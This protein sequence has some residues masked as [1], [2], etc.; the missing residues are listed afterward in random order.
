MG[1]REKRAAGSGGKVRRWTKSEVFVANITSGAIDPRSD[2]FLATYE[3]RRL[4]MVVIKRDGARCACCGASP[5]SGAVINVDHIKPR[6]LFPQLAM[7]ENNLQVLCQDCNHGKSNWDMTDW[8]VADEAT[9]DPADEFRSR[10]QAI[11]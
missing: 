5:D 6:R 1:K 9:Y 7:D 8:R 10:V 2:E 4:R 11:R 3:W